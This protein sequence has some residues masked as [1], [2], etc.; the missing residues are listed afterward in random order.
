M[1]IVI[2]TQN[3]SLVF[4]PKNIYACKYDNVF[5]L[6]NVVGDSDLDLLGTYKTKKRAQEVINNLY[7]L[8]ESVSGTASTLFTYE[9]P[10]E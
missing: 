7:V 4:D 1:T 5:R 10:K 8:L 9:I 2:K 3:G 6:Q